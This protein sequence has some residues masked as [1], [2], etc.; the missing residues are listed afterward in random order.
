MYGCLINQDELRDDNDCE[1]SSV[2]LP[3]PSKRPKIQKSLPLLTD[4]RMAKLTE[5][6]QK[7]RDYFLNKRLK[8]YWEDENQW[9]AGT[10]V[11]CFI[12]KEEARI[13]R[14]NVSRFLYQ[15]VV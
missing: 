15:F 3:P 12:D 2:D 10:V 1:L 7:K 4:K 8:I 11:E 6:L 14:S 13:V 5:Q 9:F